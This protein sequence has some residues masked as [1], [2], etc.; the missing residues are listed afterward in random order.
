MQYRLTL[1]AVF[2]ALLAGCGNGN[3]VVAPIPPKPATGSIAVVTD[4]TGA[5]VFLDHVGL[6]KVT[7]VLITDVSVGTHIVTVIMSEYL[8]ATDT[9]EVKKDST[10]AVN[11]T[12]VPDPASL[13]GNISVS[14]NPSGA[15][16]FLDG[17]SMNYTTPVVLTRVPVGTHIVRLEK[18]T[19]L[20]AADTVEVT[21]GATTTVTL[22]LVPDPAS[23]IGNISVSS[24][25][26]GASVFLD[27]KD[28]GRT[29]PTQ[30]TD[31][32]VGTHIVRLEKSTYLPAADTV[33][34]NR[35][36][37]VYVYLTLTPMPRALTVESSP[38]GA[39]I[40]L[41]GIDTGRL[42]PALFDPYPDATY[43]IR[44]ELRG[45]LPAEQ[46]GTLNVS[47]R[48]TVSL[49]LVQSPPYTLALAKSGA[50]LSLM[51]LDDLQ[52]RQ[53]A[54]D[55]ASGWLRWS[56]DGQYLAYAAGGGI[57]VLNRDGSLKA[58]LN[59]HTAWDFS[60]SNDGT[61][62]VDGVYADG[63]YQYR[64]TDDS[65]T[66][67]RGSGGLVYDHNPIFSPGDTAIAF[68]HH[69]YE[70]SVRI[71]LMKPDGTGARAVSDTFYTR[72]RDVYI[73][74][75]WVS[76]TIIAFTAEAAST[77]PN[78]GVFTLDMTTSEIRNVIS[79]SLAN[80]FRVSPDRQRFLYGGTDGVYLGSTATWTA[81][82]IAPFS[83]N[84]ISWSPYND[85]AAV[86]TVTDVYWLDLHGGWSRLL[87]AAPTYYG[88]SVARQ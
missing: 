34:V 78:G 6:D 11:L 52:P 46:S 72:T 5:S 3:K 44:L 85:G 64:A 84:D 22:T 28:V 81:T 27:G 17:K 82:K 75:C 63:I 24:N 43:A 41:N 65:Y 69:E 37:W 19:Y 23:L 18:S 66:L 80:A 76:G 47:E 50:T 88:V 79:T 73:D 32:P 9:V 10:T 14:S 60:W 30:L 8:S 83:V 29:T 86:I 51:R 20:P 31:I 38:T 21:K 12:L 53:V 13:I 26:S 71:I 36:A 61:R 70:T 59:A 87:P 55:V 56:P 4:P 49:E 74:L 33:E 57:S 40:F 39:S 48:K 1:L 54:S 45:H 2:L 7:P 25:P 58:V 16:V 35:G 42:T 15:W 68:V 67:L 77:L 62:F